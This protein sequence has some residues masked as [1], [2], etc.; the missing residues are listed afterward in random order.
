MPSWQGKSKGTTLGYS[1]FV[2]VIRK[3]GV[4][5]AYFLLRLVAFYYF[6]FSRNSSKIIYDF[7]RDKLQFARLK[8]LLKLYRNYYIFGQ[9]LID[10]I[11]V[12]AVTENKFTF[13]FDGE[14]ILREITAQQKGGMLLSAHIG[15]WEIAGFLLKRLNT[16]INI[17]IFDGEHQKIKQY[18][19]SVTGGHTANFII[20]RNDLSHIYE[21]AAALK[22]NEL[23]CMHADRFMEGNKTL[24]TDFLGQPAKFPLGPFL[25]AAQFKVPVSFV[26]A[27]KETNLHYHFFA[28]QIKQYSTQLKDEF[29]RSML[30]DFAIEMEQKVKAY[31]E[32]WFNYYDFWQ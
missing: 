13:N 12:M 17:V 30:A 21:I 6:L 25:L 2:A 5:P 15:N 23:V 10:K 7:Y 11:S 16:K 20:I 22:N 31:P 9:T 8:S 14:H 28:S 27:M 24:T 1:I 3:F 4:L 26:F 19:D 29:I 18:L 32:Q